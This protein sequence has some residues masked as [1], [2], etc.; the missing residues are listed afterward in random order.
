MRFF[1][2]FLHRNDRIAINNGISLA[3]AGPGPA[4]PPRDGV[5][6]GA[7]L[8]CDPS[9]PDPLPLPS[10]PLIRNSQEGRPRPGRA[11]AGAGSGSVWVWGWCLSVCLVSGSV[12][13]AG[14]ALGLSGCLA[15]NSCL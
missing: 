4:G 8:D 11:G 2:G 1:L 5:Q 6:R 14:S 12:W 10:L 9:P 15:G 3:P 13:L 7:R